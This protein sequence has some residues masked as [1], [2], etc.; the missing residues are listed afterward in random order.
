ME[1]DLKDKEKNPPKGQ[2]ITRRRFLKTVGSGAAVAAA[3]DVLTGLGT[4]QAAAAKPEEIVR[5]HLL[6]NGHS[7]RL[8]VESRWSLLFVL[9]E[10]LG[11]TGT[12][13]GCERGECGACTVLIDGVPRYACMTLAVEAE[14]KEII[15]LEGL[16]N[17][18]ELG[19][20]QQAFVEHD[21]LQC[22]YCTSG[23]IMAAEGLLRQSPSPTMD[24]I[25][26]GMSGNLCRCGAYTHI[27]K[28]VDRAARLRK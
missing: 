1:N 12:K 24:E 9:R 6:V 11:L 25:R 27:F 14:G 21:A 28:A 22:G 20:V 16:M 5:V 3:S 15:S 4:V 10:R 18:E 2:G 23:Q 26:M 8:A 7:H 19:P 13:V 17:G